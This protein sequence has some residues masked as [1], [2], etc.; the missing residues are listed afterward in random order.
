M[1]SSR[2][3]LIAAAAGEKG[4]HNGGSGHVLIP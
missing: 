4:T 3:K 2:P 1:N